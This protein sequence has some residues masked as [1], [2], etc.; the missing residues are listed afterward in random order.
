MALTSHP[1]SFHH[2]KEFYVRGRCQHTQ[3]PRNPQYVDLH[4]QKLLCLK[5]DHFALKAWDKLAAPFRQVQVNEL[6]GAAS[7][8]EPRKRIGRRHH[9]TVLVPL[10]GSLL[11]KAVCPGIQWG[12]QSGSL[13]KGTKEGCTGGGEWTSRDISGSCC[14]LEI[15]KFGSTKLES[16]AR[17]GLSIDRNV[18][19]QC[20]QAWYCSW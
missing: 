9:A 18:A 19:S 11:P 16:V 6:W 10:F 17:I 14:C 3:V 7:L 5:T 20:H 13:W 12:C 1:F 2:T 15:G 8:K 4:P